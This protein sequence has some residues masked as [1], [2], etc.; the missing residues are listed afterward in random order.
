MSHSPGISVRPDPSILR[1]PRAETSSTGPIPVMRPPRTTTDCPGSAGDPVPSI[2]V[3]FYGTRWVEGEQTGQTERR[4]GVSC[5]RVT[6]ERTRTY[7]EDGRTETDTVFALYRPEGVR[8]DGSPSDPAARTTTT[9]TTT[10]STV[11]PSTTVP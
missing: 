8:C 2:T 4:Q 1:A 7:L 11:P 3:T 10:T 6:T 5:T 9:T